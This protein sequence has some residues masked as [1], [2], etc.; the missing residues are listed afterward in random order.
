MSKLPAKFGFVSVK[1][2]IDHAIEEGNRLF[3]GTRF[4]NMWCIYHD[5][6]S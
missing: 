1:D 6:L 3:A 4:A 2:L 5:A